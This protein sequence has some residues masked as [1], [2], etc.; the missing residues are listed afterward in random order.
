MISNE[1]GIS[2]VL[3]QGWLGDSA[4]RATKCIKDEKCSSETCCHG[5]DKNFNL[6]SHHKF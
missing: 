3:I 4:E 1:K 6:V 2:S 5:A